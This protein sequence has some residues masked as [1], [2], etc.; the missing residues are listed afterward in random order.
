MKKT[1]IALA[2]AST[3]ALTACGNDEP[4]GTDT[5]MEDPTVSQWE[6]PEVRGP[7]QDT[8]QEDVDKVAHDVV[9]QI[10]SWSPKDDHTL[11]LIHI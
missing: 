6:Q 3:V 4:D 1:A 10:F 5:G 7:L 11:S 8:D 2:L 9:K